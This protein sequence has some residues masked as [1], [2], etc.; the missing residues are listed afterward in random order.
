MGIRRT[1]RPDILYSMTKFALML[2]AVVTLPAQDGWDRV[3]G[4]K[5][6]QLV[7]VSHAKGFAEGPLV[8]VGPDRIVVKAAGKDLTVARVDAKKIW[9]PANKRGR[10]AVI[11][12]A[13]GAGVTFFPAILLGSYFN[14]EG[15]NGLKVAIATM[16]VG[17]G[18]GASLGSLNRGRTLIYRR[19]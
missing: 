19:R 2:L 17:T 12:A 4:L 6:G 16:A 18:A 3:A 15:G 5:P 13:I 7:L 14:N 9:L 11:G 8:E 10:N 1:V